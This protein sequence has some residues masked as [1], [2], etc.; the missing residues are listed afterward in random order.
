MKTENKTADPKVGDVVL[1]GSDGKKRFEWPLGRIIELF[2]GK[3]GK[4]R[5]VKVKTKNGVYLRPIQRLYPLEVSSPIR[6]ITKKEEADP[7]DT[8]KNMCE[9]KKA[10]DPKDANKNMRE[11]KKAKDPK[12]TNKNVC[13][14]VKVIKTKLGRQV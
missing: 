5:V 10:K 13:E 12:G 4:T 11:E 8:N 2:P 7:K 1:V 3:D 6:P 9:E 14:D